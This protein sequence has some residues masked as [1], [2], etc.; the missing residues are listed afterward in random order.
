MK[1]ENIIILILLTAVIAGFIYEAYSSGPVTFNRDNIR[2][3]L[4][5]LVFGIMGIVMRLIFWKTGVNL[6]KLVISTIIFVLT[7]IVYIVTYNV[8]W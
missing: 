8:I 3:V 4:P 5:I 2:S 6:K 7:I 1:R